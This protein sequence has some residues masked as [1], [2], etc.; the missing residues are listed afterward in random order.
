MLACGYRWKRS[1]FTGELGRCWWAHPQAQEILCQNQTVYQCLQRAIFR[2]ESF[3]SRLYLFIIQRE[4][5]SLMDWSTYG[6]RSSSSSSQSLLKQTMYPAGND[7]SST[8]KFETH[9]DCETE[10]TGLYNSDCPFLVVK[11]ENDPSSWLKRPSAIM[12]YLQSRISK[13]H[14]IAICLCSLVLWVCRTYNC[15]F[16]L[17]RVVAF[18]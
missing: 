10:T 15:R 6:S 2:D 14:V 8:L 7:S 18:R 9:A 1:P 3:L 17:E 5:T 4:K 13:F 11:P 16:V 12:N